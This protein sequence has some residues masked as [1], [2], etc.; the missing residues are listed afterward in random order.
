MT[1]KIVLPK[2]RVHEVPRLL[3]ADAYT[4]GGDKFQSAKAK[5]KSVYYVTFRRNLHD[6][7]NFLYRKEDNR[8]YF[9]GLQRILER[10]L[11]KP[12]THEEIDRAVE[13]LKHAKITQSGFKNYECPEH[14]WRRVV[15]EFN[16]YPP[17]KITAMPEGSVVYPNEPTIMCQSL[18]DGFGELGVWFESNILHVYGASER[19]TQ[20]RHWLVKLMEMVDMVNPNLPY[21]EKQFIA[22]LML[23]DFGDRAALTEMESEDLGM[24]HLYTY[25]GTD[26]FSGAYQAW[27]NSDKTVGLFS[28]VNALAHRNVQA[29][30]NEGDCY[31]TMYNLADPDEFLSMVGDCYN[32]KNAVRKY[33]IPLALKS[34]ELKN[35]IVIVSRPDSG[36]AKEQILWAIDLAI[37]NGLYT[38]Q[39][40]N[41]KEWKFGT[42]FR[43]IE[44]DGM[45][46]EVMWDI[47]MALIEKGYAP[48]GWLLFGVGGGNR[49]S[50][51]RDNTS[52][53]YALCAMGNDLQ[54]VCK[55][56]E[57]LGKGTLGGVFKVLR[58]EEALKNKKTVVSIDE[59]G[60]NAMV[61]YYCGLPDNDDV[62]KPFGEGQE[63]DFVQIK[64]RMNEQFKNM[65][66][67]MTTEE[68]HN[69]PISEKLH[70]IREA[71]VEKYKPN[72]H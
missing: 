52:A 8:I 7:N 58:D 60:E 53:K 17:I 51:K 54:E 42:T 30:D 25:G 48:Y 72:V 70:N 35:N 41:G 3:K 61:V 62:F 56:S 15:D 66:L 23:T 50:L 6:I 36:D 46:H 34:K 69:F 26:T 71:L 1:L 31:N 11:Y 4:I 29:Y 44:G 12:V 33:H 16:G 37:K 19:A 59:E 57:V 9:V 20:D 22:S 68:N 63:H 21:E 45:T 32:Y 13:F 47:M 65:P 14:L 64:N 43:I 49:N 67:S 55:F 39:V 5:E 38:T 24:T 27:M 40:I 2:K 28:S 10:L 18:V